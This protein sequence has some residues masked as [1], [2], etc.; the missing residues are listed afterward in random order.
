MVLDP[1]TVI[2]KDYQGGTYV[3]RMRLR[4]NLR[5]RFGGFRGGKVIAMPEGEYVYVGSALSQRGATALGRRLVRHASR[6]EGKSNQAIR[7]TMVKRFREIGLG[8]GDLLPR[9]EKKMHWNVDH[10]LD[11]REVRLTHVIAIRSPKRVEGAI[12]QLLEQDCHTMIIEKGLGAN[13]MP[14]N[15]HL[16]K[17][18]AEEAWWVELVGRLE[19][20]VV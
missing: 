13:D 20:L 2:G 17:V 4:R 10:L 6:S 18:E 1:I 3:L 11:R 8:E 9:S 7:R 15:T 19:A 16:V 5:L 12:G 14:G